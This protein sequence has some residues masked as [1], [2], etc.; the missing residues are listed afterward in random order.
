[1]ET[2]SNQNVTWESQR[3]D[4]CEYINIYLKTKECEDVTWIEMA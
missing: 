4:T 2:E 3:E 1:M